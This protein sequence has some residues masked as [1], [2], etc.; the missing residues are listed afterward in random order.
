[1]CADTAPS[2]SVATSRKETF[3]VAVIGAG[4]SGLVAAKELLEE[5]LQVTV[6]E[7]STEV[8]GIWIYDE[9]AEDDLLSQREDRGKVHS[10][11]YASLRTNLPREVMSYLDLPFIPEAMQGKSQ[12]SRRFCSHEEVLEYLKVYCEVY[13]LS[14]VIKFGRR[15][16]KAIPQ[17]VD[18]SDGT[19]AG[20]CIHS[21]GA[22]GAEEEHF[23]ALVVAN[24]HYTQP[25]VP[26]PPLPGADTFPGT[27]MH[28]HN[29]RR[30]GPFA[31]QVVVVV[32]A[33]SSGQ[34]ISREVSQ[35]AR[36]VYLCSR[37][38]PDPA[39]GTDPTPHGPRGNIWRR[40]NLAALHPDGSAEFEGGMAVSGVDAVVYCTGYRYSFPF[41]QDAG[42]VSLERN[43][44]EPLYEQVFVPAL[45]P[46]LA[47]IG[48]PFN[49]VAF[50]L[51][52]M[53]AK[54]VARVLSGRR[55]L[56]PAG[57]MAGEAE[58]LYAEVDATGLPGRY[59]H[60]M[61][62]SQW[63]YINR[64]ADYCGD[65]GKLSPW[66]EPMY[67]AS[68]RNKRE[69][70]ETYRDSQTDFELQRAAAA[71]FGEALQRLGAAAAAG[72]A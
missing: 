42:V 43:R 6:Y 35:V 12:D 64:L 58:R 68:S 9:A 28:S 44:V 40:N 52:D 56:P 71:D 26:E 4:A 5:G 33:Q 39:M 1:M 70:P 13:G 19:C 38:W 30:P 3:N 14:E 54:W 2:S 55:A 47:F 46:R 57:E 36:E 24:G 17:P 48:L 49:V 66:R 22:T 27:Q 7:A 72:R 69:N 15:V 18:C 25:N 20:W 60:E 61:R 32:G 41:L 16:T 53:Q 10:S 45:A 63:E 11:M 29:Y 51:F 65:V 59:A 37:S 23:D 62:N 31:G 21:E 34:D 50:Q 67:K 8:G